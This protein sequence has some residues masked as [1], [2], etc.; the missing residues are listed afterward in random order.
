MI[1]KMLANTPKM[2]QGP[3][4]A[5]FLLR[6]LGVC[7]DLQHRVER[8]ER[9]YRRQSAAAVASLR[10]N[11]TRLVASRYLTRWVTFLLRRV[12]SRG[13]GTALPFGIGYPSSHGS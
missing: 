9:R 6:V 8:L 3:D 13:Q 12:K 7:T 2:F 5:P 11:N 10:A 4:P 1:R